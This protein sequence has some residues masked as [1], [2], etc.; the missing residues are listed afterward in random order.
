MRRG[1]RENSEVN[2]HRSDDF[3]VFMERVVTLLRQS[4][5]SAIPAA[6]FLLTTRLM[7]S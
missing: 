1:W 2:K 3:N 7:K 5:K 6:R 4:G